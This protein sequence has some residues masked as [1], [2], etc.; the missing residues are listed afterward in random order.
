V[1]APDQMGFGKSSKPFGYQYSFALLAQH[2]RALL[3]S[4]GIERCAVLGHSTG[5]ML[6]VRYAYCAGAGIR[7]TKRSRSCRWAGP[8]VATIRAK[9]TR[10]AIPGSELVELDGVGHVPQVEAFDRFRAALLHCLA[11]P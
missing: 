5:G 9:K 2:T 3:A 4:L 10:D 11:T 8:G 1:I 7:L 6:A